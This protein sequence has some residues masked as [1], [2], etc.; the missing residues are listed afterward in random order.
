MSQRWYDNPWIWGGVG[1]TA[2]ALIFVPD[3]QYAVKDIFVRGEKLTSGDWWD[4]NPAYGFI[5]DDPSSLAATASIALGTTVDLDTYSLARMIR[6]EGA[7]QGLVRA[8]VALNDLAVFPYAD[9][10]TELVTYSTDKK[11]RGYYG[12]QYSPAMPPTFPD[13]NKR[14]YSTASDPYEGDVQ[15]AAQA[16]AERAAGVD[17]VDG[18]TK[19]IDRGSMGVQLGSASFEKTDATW[20][21]DGMVAF[22]LPEL[23]DNLVLYK[24]G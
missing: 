22:T 24:K 3:A 6:S 5:A 13:A 18:A 1:V 15:M 7:A 23:G 16:I 11:R 10:I 14:R 20:K 9:T 12:K 4:G 17:R 8:H 19:F 21:A 2:L